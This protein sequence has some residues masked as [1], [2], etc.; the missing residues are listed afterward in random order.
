MENLIKTV[1]FQR[2][3]YSSGNYSIEFIF[4]DVRKRLSDKIYA[5]V[6]VST[7]HSQGIFKRLYNM[8]EVVF[9]QGEVNFIT[10]D[11][12]YI[13]F[14]LKKK[15]TILTIMD[16]GFLYDSG[17]LSSWLQ[18]LL[19]LKIP[20]RRVKYITTISPNSK[21][22]IL[23]YTDCDPDKI[24]IIPVAISSIYKYYPKKIR[25]DKPI[26]LQIG[27]AKNKNLHRIIEA[28]KEMNVQLSIIGEIR[29]ENKMLLEKYNVDYTNVFNISDEEILQKYIDCD[30]LVFPS[31]YE[32]FGMPI[33]EAQAVG[34][35]VLAAN[36]TSMPWVSGNAAYLCDPYSVESIRKG[37]S[38]IL[39]DKTFTE[40]LIIKGLENVKRFAPDIIANQYLELIKLVRKQ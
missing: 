13:S 23:K 39:E 27:Q 40:N 38:K 5:S 4:D 24:K 25:N 35:P 37:I 15:K 9:N 28:I 31:T 7:Y 1:F 22:D 11:I 16:S 34:R 21:S 36:T 2:K 20:T 32:G 29:P 17:R 8:I 10:G 6:F 12:H 33:I 30:V 19:W 14:F 26:L 3:Q 18:T